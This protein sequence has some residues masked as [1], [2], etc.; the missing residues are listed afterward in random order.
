MHV[1]KFGK[2]QSEY[3]FVTTVLKL[4]TLSYTEAV[5]RERHIFATE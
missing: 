4:T 1:A 5:Q 3:E 2:S